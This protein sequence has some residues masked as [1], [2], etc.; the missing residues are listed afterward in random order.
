MNRHE[1]RK[2]ARQNRT[3]AFDTATLPRAQAF[4]DAFAEAPNDADIEVRIGVSENGEAGVLVS[5]QDGGDHPLF[6]REARILADIMEKTMNKYPNDPEAATLPNIIMALR[7]GCDAA[8]TA[9][10]S[11]D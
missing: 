4:L 3:V 7:A 10:K 8:E 5:I 1:R 6:V 2:A 11:H 9:L